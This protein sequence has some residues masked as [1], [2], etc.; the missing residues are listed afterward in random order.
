MVQFPAG[1]RHFSI[2]NSIQANS[3][4]L[5]G[6]PIQWILEAVSSEVKQLVMKLI[7]LLSSAKIH[8][9]LS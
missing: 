8:N 5:L 3:D 7:S 9:A 4:A 6:N 1:T 2:V